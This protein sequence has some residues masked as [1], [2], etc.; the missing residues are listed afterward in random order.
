MFAHRTSI[1]RSPLYTR[2][3]RK[4]IFVFY[5]ERKFAVSRLYLVASGNLTGVLI[6]EP[7]GKASFVYIRMQ[8][9]TEVYVSKPLITLIAV[10]VPRNAT[11]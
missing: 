1:T 7:A 6:V 10:I 3:S 8:M 9:L 5:T 11:S 4:E 2:S